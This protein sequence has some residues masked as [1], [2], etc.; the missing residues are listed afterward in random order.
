MVAMYI[1]L[2][3]IDNEVKICCENQK[4]TLMVMR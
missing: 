1:S 4:I 3:L 2:L